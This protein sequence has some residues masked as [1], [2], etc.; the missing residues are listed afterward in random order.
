LGGPARPM[1]D[2]WKEEL[3]RIR[4]RLRLLDAERAELMA[5]LGE[6][7]RQ[8]PVPAPVVY[9]AHVRT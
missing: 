5:K 2:Q 4:A 7:E 9:S 1:D 8:P 6:L 3:A